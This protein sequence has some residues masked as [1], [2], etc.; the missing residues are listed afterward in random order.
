MTDFDTR[1]REGLSAEDE[2]FLADLEDGRGLFT[3]LGTTMTGPMGGWGVYAIILAAVMFALLVFSAFSAWTAEELRPTVL[4]SA[5]T[6]ALVVMT[7]L[8]KLWVFSRMNHL[9]TLRELK[10]IELRLLRQREG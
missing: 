9:A 4:W 2:R 10:K 5:A 6:V 1:L 8:V 3:Q 7:G